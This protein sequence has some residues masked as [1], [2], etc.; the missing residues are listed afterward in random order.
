VRRIMNEVT[1]DGTPSRRED[2]GF[3]ERTGLDWHDVIS[4]RILVYTML[5]LRYPFFLCRAV[6]AGREVA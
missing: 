1:E 6:V 3:R 5:S 2:V 4:C